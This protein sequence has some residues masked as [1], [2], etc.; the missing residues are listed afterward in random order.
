MGTAYL[1]FIGISHN[2]DNFSLF[3]SPCRF[4][5]NAPHHY[6]MGNIA[7]RR[8]FVQFMFSNPYSLELIESMRKE[9]HLRKVQDELLFSTLAYNPHLGAPG[10]CLR[11]HAITPTD[12]RS[13][14]LA[15]FVNWNATDCP[16]RY[17]VHGVCIFGARDVPILIE[18]PHLFANKFFWN[19]EPV[20]YTCMEYWLVKRIQYERI[21][22]SLH[23]SFN[24]SL[25]ANLYCSSE[26]I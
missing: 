23:P 14:F 1:M 4:L 6:T 15:R 10:A 7:L 11:P 18:Q 21:F 17:A 12:P 24:R 16:S 19:F 22:R 5:R 9:S 20:A 8:E 26:H 3:I 13:W 2:S 25:Y